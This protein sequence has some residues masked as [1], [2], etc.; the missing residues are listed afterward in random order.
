MTDEKLYR[1]LGLL[2]HQKTAGLVTGE[3]KEII[4]KEL[5]SLLEVAKLGKKEPFYM[6]L[7]RV[8]N[9]IPL[10][11]REFAINTF[12]NASPEG[13]II[14]HAGN[15]YFKLGKH[16]AKSPLTPQIKPVVNKEQ[17]DAI[18]F[19]KWLN[20]NKELSQKDEKLLGLLELLQHRKFAQEQELDANKP[21]D[22]AEEKAQRVAWALG[23]G[24]ISTLQSLAIALALEGILKRM[25]G[26]PEPKMSKL[27]RAIMPLFRRETPALKAK[28]FVGKTLRK[29]KYA[30]PY[31]L[32]TGAVL[33]SIKG[34]GEQGLSQ[35]FKR[36]LY[37]YYSRKYSRA[38]APE[39]PIQNI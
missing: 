24:T 12:L 11:Y 18:R 2:Q 10:K 25:E 20:L 14:G 15:R 21:T 3:A 17:L 16:F 28:M 32:L 23:K 29:L 39:Q 22:L 31:A 35:I 26:P 4:L 27:T 19:G 37:R 8:G 6:T 7:E 36:P 33:G 13:T 9:K 5:K 34:Y 38:Q 1:L 30:V